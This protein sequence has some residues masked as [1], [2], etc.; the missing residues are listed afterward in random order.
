M[1]A[2]AAHGRDDE[3]EHYGDQAAYQAAE[4]LLAELAGSRAW[5]AVGLVVGRVRAAQGDGRGQRRAESGD[6]LGDELLAPR[7]SQDLVGSRR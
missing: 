7:I 3:H 2:A 1:K 6:G 5:R 4:L